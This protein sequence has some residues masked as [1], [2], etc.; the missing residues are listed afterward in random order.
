MYSLVETH[1]IALAT[2]LDWVKHCPLYTGPLENM[3]TLTL[4]L[5]YGRMSLKVL[6]T[7]LREI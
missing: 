5:I 6:H 4:V 1:Q 3:I 7:C 2:H